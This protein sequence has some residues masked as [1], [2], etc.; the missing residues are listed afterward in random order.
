MR[1]SKRDRKVITIGAVAGGLIL[2]FFYGLLPAYDN[3]AAVD[4][5]LGQKK[6]LLVRHLRVIAGESRYEGRLEEL[7]RE[8]N[9]L[10]GQLLDASESTIAQNQLENI[11]RSL[12]DQ[13]GLAISRSTPL[14][15]RK[16][17]EN[18]SKVTLQIN[19]QGGMLELANFLHALS[20][21]SKFLEVDELYVN[22]FRVRNQD[23]RIQPRLN[24]SGFIRAGESES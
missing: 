12:A 6:E 19:V 14:Q 18:Y 17:G 15:E 4:E 2:I 3:L 16:V 5:D 22:G 9:R 11:V 8:L 23:V 24:I 20:T 10:A 7:D 1:I 21:H 13:S